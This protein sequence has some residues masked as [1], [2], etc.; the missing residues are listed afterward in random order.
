MLSVANEEGDVV[1]QLGPIS[2]LGSGVVREIITS[3]LKENKNYS[4][5]VKIKMFSQTLTS[6][7]DFICKLVYL[8]DL[9]ISLINNK[10]VA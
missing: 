6:H 7:H 5:S 2:H 10:Y 1:T 9:S 3:N 8:I 4:L